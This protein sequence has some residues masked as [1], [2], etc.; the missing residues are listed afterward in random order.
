MCKELRGRGKIWNQ[1]YLFDFQIKKDLFKRPL[2]SELSALGGA[3]TQAVIQSTLSKELHF[4]K[5][6]EAE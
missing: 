5:K 3:N 2:H 4:R 1:S 6:R